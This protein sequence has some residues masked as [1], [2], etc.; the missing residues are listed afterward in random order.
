[1]RF[2]KENQEELTPEKILGFHSGKHTGNNS[3]NVIMQRE[4]GLKTVSI[5][6]VTP[7]GSKLKM[8]YTDLIKHS[9]QEVII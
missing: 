6:Q 8:Q 3:I 9:L 1:M 7:D 4:G 2:Y 5:T